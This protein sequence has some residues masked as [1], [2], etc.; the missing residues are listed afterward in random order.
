MPARLVVDNLVVMSCCFEDEGNSF[1]DPVL[2]NL[3]SGEAF[4]PAI[5]PDCPSP[6]N[7]RLPNG[8]PERLFRSRESMGSPPTTPLLLL[9]EPSTVT[10]IPLKKQG[11]T[12]NSPTLPFYS[13]FDMLKEVVEEHEK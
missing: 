1:A 2:E 8:C 3:E 10:D 11:R 5:W 13:F 9:H 6:W 4:V 12:E 7:R